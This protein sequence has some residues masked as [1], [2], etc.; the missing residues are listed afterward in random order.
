M[1]PRQTKCYAKA[2]TELQELFREIS[3]QGQ[4]GWLELQTALLPF[5]AGDARNDVLEL[6]ED[7]KLKQT[8]LNEQEFIRVMWKKMYYD[9]VVYTSKYR[10]SEGKA[11]AGCGAVEDDGV[12]FNIPLAHVIVSIKRRSQLKQFAEYYASRGISGA[13]RLTAETAGG[14]AGTHVESS[15][16]RRRSPRH[17]H[18]PRHHRHRRRACMLD[19]SIAVSISSLRERTSSAYDV[20][21]C[22]FDPE[23]RAMRPLTLFM[24]SH[25]TQQVR[26]VFLQDQQRRKSASHMASC[27]VNAASDPPSYISQ[28]GDILVMN[29]LED[30]GLRNVVTATSGR[31]T[32]IA[33]TER[34]VH[35][36]SEPQ[37]NISPMIKSALEINQPGAAEDETDLGFEDPR[38]AALSPA[39]D[40]DEEGDCVGILGGKKL[41]ARAKAIAD[42]ASIKQIVAGDNFAMAVTLT[43]EMFTWGPSLLGQD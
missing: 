24:S 33:C 39:V 17:A 42:V 1:D 36:W 23:D 19:K 8:T 13:D 20:V 34:K 4:V 2:Q 22:V 11:A 31:G 41:L 25:F 15:P 18:S 10:E 7:M 6:V 27:T 32:F 9:N 38:N 3:S 14:E 28:R 30:L 40:L 37:P 5:T 35:Q 29:K 12:V 16:T 26:H 21:A 43:G